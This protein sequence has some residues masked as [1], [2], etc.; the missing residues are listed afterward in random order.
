LL[1][2]KAFCLRAKN[3]QDLTTGVQHNFAILAAF[4]HA[5]GEWCL[6][7]CEVEIEKE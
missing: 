5:N 2:G 7:I 4:D 3:A 1:V 6:E